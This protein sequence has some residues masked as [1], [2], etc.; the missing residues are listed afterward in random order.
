MVLHPCR[1]FPPHPVPLSPLQTTALVTVPKGLR[2]CSYMCSSKIYRPQA[3]D[4]K[5]VQPRQRGPVAACG[6]DMREGQ[7]EWPGGYAGAN[8]PYLRRA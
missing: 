7:P 8:P 3:T 4:K 2:L 1:T 5:Y 6:R